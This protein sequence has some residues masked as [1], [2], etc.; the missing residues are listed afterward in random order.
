MALGGAA[1][2][3]HKDW[4]GAIAYIKEASKDF[5]IIRDD[6]FKLRDF[7]QLLTKTKKEFS[8]S[9]E[10]QREL[11]TQTERLRTSSCLS[12]HLFDHALD[13]TPEPGMYLSDRF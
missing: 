12:P 1:V 10:V 4:R 5:E 3:D 9:Q 13:L 11:L 6:P 8:A 7:V 2:G